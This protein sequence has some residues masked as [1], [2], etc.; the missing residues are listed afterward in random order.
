MAAEIVNL[1]DLGFKYFKR[2]TDKVSLFAGAT[3]II[4]E[5]NVIQK[6]PAYTIEC[7]SARAASMKFNHMFKEY[8][9]AVTI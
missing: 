5:P 9:K 1:K 3:V 7:K 8:N 4:V 2:S 6:K